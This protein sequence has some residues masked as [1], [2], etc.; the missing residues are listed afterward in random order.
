MEA[1]DPVIVVKLVLDGTDAEFAELTFEEPPV[2]GDRI[3]VAGR[4]SVR[5][6]EVLSRTWQSAVHREEPNNVIALW[7]RDLKAT[8]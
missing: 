5:H 8:R 2:V 3:W 7:V 4:A 1:G 6:V